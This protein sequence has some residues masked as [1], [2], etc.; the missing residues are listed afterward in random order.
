[1]PSAVYDRV[2]EK[3]TD[4]ARQ[5]KD[6]DAHVASFLSES[7]TAAVRF[8]NP[9]IA[10]GPSACERLRTGFREGDGSALDAGFSLL[11]IL[12][13]TETVGKALLSDVTLVSDADAVAEMLEHGGFS[14]TIRL[15][16]NSN[17]RTIEPGTVMVA[18]PLLLQRVLMRSVILVTLSE[19]DAGCMG[20]VLNHPLPVKVGNFVNP[21]GTGN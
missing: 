10:G 3:W 11:R 5:Y 13:K 9:Q 18:H 20:L 8:Y 2:H 6:V 16:G 19:G 4:Q 12:A 15:E 7:E 1:M 17:R 14:P 21:K